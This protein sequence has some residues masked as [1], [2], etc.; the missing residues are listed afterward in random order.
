[1][2]VTRDTKHYLICFVADGF[3]AIAFMTTTL[4]LAERFNGIG[5]WSKFQV[6]FMLGYGSVV[7]GLIDIFF[8]YNL[9]MI[10]RR[11]GRGQ[12]DHSLIQ[13]QPVWMTLCTEGFSPFQ[14]M[15]YMLPGS[16]L[17]VWSAIRLGQPA[18]LGWLALL[19]VSIAGS[20]MVVLSFAYLWGSLAFWFP[21]SAEEVNSATSQLMGSLRVFPLDGLGH[22]LVGG[23]LTIIPAG[24]MAW[25][26]CKC[27]LGLDR[28]PWHSAVTPMAGVAF[29][30]VMV[31]VFGRGM[32][33]YGRTGSQRYSDF[34]HR[35]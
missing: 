28:V 27:L 22:L 2:W 31:Y 35:R 13:P 16:A 29:F 30:V 3:A 32:D 4:L 19:S 18:E 10:S 1:M 24:L 9:C 8:G 26:P 23:L 5:Q 20:C 6:I 7:R 17:M 25:Y 14:N 12:L 21:R 15:A 11:L 33:Y 34:G